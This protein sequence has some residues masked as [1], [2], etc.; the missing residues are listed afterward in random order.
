MLPQVTPSPNEFR[1]AELQA[2][3]AQLREE[4]AGME[5]RLRE[6]HAKFRATFD[7]AAVG[8]AHV[9]I[10]G[11]WLEVNEKL[12]EIVGYTREELL[13]LSFQDITYPDDLQ[14]DLDLVHQLLAG[15][16]PGY[17]LEKRYLRKDRSLVWIKL[18][19]SL[20]RDA[21]G[22]PEYFVSVIES[23]NDRKLAEQERERVKQALAFS[24]SRFRTA[25]DNI[26]DVIVIYDRE[27]RIQ[28]VNPATVQITGM[29]PS[30]FIGKR[31]DEIFPAELIAPWQPAMR[32]A[33]DEGLVQTVEVSLPMST[34]MRNLVITCVPIRDQQGQINELMGITHDVSDRR[35]AE[36]EAVKAALHDKLT[37]LPNR[38]LL[39]EYSA[40]VFDQAARNQHEGGVLFIDL[41]RFKPINDLH[42]HQ[43]GDAVLRE[44]ARR[45]KAQVRKADLVF[46]LGGDEFLVLLPQLVNSTEAAT[47]AQRIVQVLAAPIMAE[48]IELQMSAS[49]GI[50]VFP[51][52]GMDMQSLVNA[53][54]SAMYHAKQSGKNNWQF[55]SAD[56]SG[57]V[58]AQMS[59]QDR[60]RGA[61][62]RR[63]FSLVFQPVLDLKTG[64]LASVEALLRWPKSGVGPDQFIPAAEAVGQIVAIG[65]WVMQE[66]CRAHKRW[67]ERGLPPIPVAVN[68]SALQ[69]RQKDFRFKVLGVLRRE[70]LPADALQIELT[71]STLLEDVDYT[72]Y[73]L[74]K[75]RQDGVRIS[76]DDFGT[77]YSSLSYLSR[78]PV[79]KIKI[80]KSFTRHLTT[81]ATSRAVTEA[82]I[83]LSR[84]LELEVVAEG[85]ETQTMFDE[86][87]R[88]GCQQAQ[89]H[90]ISTPLAA[91]Q[92][93]A[94]YLDR[95]ATRA[96]RRQPVP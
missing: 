82:I 72:I 54:D 84:R 80:D 11:S 69:M 59:L 70:R 46:R 30:E 60:V 34:G 77:G 66:A 96:S 28:Y 79:N 26:P 43:T 18:N 21:H 36:Q 73:L 10:D 41:D 19:V 81:D 62:K 5:Q 24:E 23:I 87:R 78:L 29:Q 31:E 17:C 76:L 47:I 74:T 15:E 25:F 8:I 56:L 40:H 91:E 75:L 48:G 9:A 55:F 1:I 63:E 94:W 93:E 51:R 2:E 35:R 85:I 58:H 14:A 7:L 32:A 13:A 86:V 88:L 57:R 39:F 20:A 89:G 68:V 67:R 90:L 52:D 53:A 49:I 95:Q 33:L 3:V 16:I 38:A 12:C 42:G 50:S 4:I 27:L 22:K 92:F 37:G 45:I 44:V 71:E 6:K 61:L 65:D 64:A 83:T